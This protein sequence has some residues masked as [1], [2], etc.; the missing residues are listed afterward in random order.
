MKYRE[1]IEKIDFEAIKEAKEYVYENKENISADYAK[2]NLPSPEY[3]KITSLLTSQSRSPLWEKAFIMKSG[4]EK[5]DAK[6]NKGDFLLNGIYYEY[7]ISG[8]NKGDLLHMVQ[9]RLWQ[10]VSY[11]IQ[12][13][14]PNFELVTF[15]LTHE[16]MEDELKR[17]NATAAHG[18]AEANKNNENV[19][20]RTT[21]APDSEDMKRWMANYK[22]DKYD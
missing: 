11:I 17:M 7:K 4:A 3:F 6:D 10:N 9:V 20:F 15:E 19:E 14:D 21:I 1:L 13:V 5:V 16:Q 12:Y 22:T 8:P 18:T 2:G